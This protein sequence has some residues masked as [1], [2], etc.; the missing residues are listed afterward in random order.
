MHGDDEA[1]R[2]HQVV[3]DAPPEAHRLRQRLQV[4]VQQHQVRRLARNLRPALAHRHAHVRR[5]QRRRVVHAV[6]NHAH[7]VAPA[8]QRL[9][10]RQ[11]VLRQHPCKHPARV[12]TLR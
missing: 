9:H 4:V 5:L 10:D 2:L 3:A 6:P 12:R 11:L 7:H 1:H 8:L